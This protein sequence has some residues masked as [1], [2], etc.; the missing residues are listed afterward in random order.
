MPKCGEV[1]RERCW[2]GAPLVN[3]SDVPITLGAWIDAN[4][5]RK[6]IPRILVTHLTGYF[7]CLVET[8]SFTLYSKFVI[9]SDARRKQMLLPCNLGRDLMIFIESN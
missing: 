5:C 4:M 1:G 2:G 9:Q 7:E 3:C 6:D 8:S